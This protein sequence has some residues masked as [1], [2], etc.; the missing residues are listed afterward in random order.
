MKTIRNFS[1]T[2]WYVALYVVGLV[3]AA[4]S[5]AQDMERILVL[6][7]PIAITAL[8]AS[9]LVPFAA[10]AKTEWLQKWLIQY[11]IVPL[12]GAYTVLA[13]HMGSLVGVVILAGA[14]AVHGGYWLASLHSRMYRVEQFKLGFANELPATAQL[15]ARLNGTG[16]SHLADAIIRAILEGEDVP[17]SILSAIRNITADKEARNAR[18]ELT[19]FAEKLRGELPELKG[20]VK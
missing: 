6:V 8:V 19:H 13:W 16:N 3:V 20:G 18:Q 4:K 2:G 11:S 17:E 14:S 9:L 1:S 15:I 5:P 12:F 7:S 10:F